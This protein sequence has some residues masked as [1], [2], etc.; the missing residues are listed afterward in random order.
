MLPVVGHQQHWLLADR[1][2]NGMRGRSARFHQHIELRGDR[3]RHHRRIAHR[4]QL[5]K[6]HPAIELAR[7]PARDRQSQP[8]FA[9]SA[10]TGQGDQPNLAAAK[11]LD[12][13]A[14]LVV[15]PN[16]PGGG[17]GKR[18]Q[19]DGAFLARGKGAGGDSVSSSGL[20]AAS[21]VARSRSAQLQ[22]IGQHAHRFQ[23]GK[24][25]R[26]AFQIAD[27][28]HAQPSPL[29]QPFLAQPSGNPIM[30]ECGPEPGNV[31]ASIRA[32]HAWLR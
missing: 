1:L 3:P 20:A 11:E 31:A 24:G 7:E 29:G 8:R 5:Q 26:A 19:I 18:S 30:P 4:R 13:L 6:R 25:A 14:N 21:N 27:A 2:G 17:N 22:R 23:P 12:D 28:A 9:D 32:V 16:Q 15:P 10:L